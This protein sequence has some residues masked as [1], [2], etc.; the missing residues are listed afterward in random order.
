VKTAYPIF[1]IQDALVL[2]PDLS[3]H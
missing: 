2:I 3:L 1:G